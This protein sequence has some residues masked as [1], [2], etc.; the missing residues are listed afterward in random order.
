MKRQLVVILL[1]CALLGCGSA[2]HVV[3]DPNATASL[4]SPDWIIKGEP[5]SEGSQVER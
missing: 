4:A 1:A 5:S 2:R 3:A